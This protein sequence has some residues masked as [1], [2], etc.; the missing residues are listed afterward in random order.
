MSST[1]QNCTCGCCNSELT[2]AC[3]YPPNEE[4]LSCQAWKCSAGFYPS[5]GSTAICP[6]GDQFNTFDVNTL[7]DIWTGQNC[8]DFYRGLIFS[9]GDSLAPTCEGLSE[10]Q[11]YMNNFLK[12][13]TSLGYDFTSDTTSSRWN[14]FQDQLISFCANN[15]L[16]PGACDLFLGNGPGIQGY[17]TKF[18]RSEIGGDIDLNDMCGCYAPSSGLSL[19]SSS[20]DS[21][22]H[23]LTTVQRPDPTLPGKTQVCSDT[24]CVLDDVNINLVNTTGNELIFRQICPACTVSHPCTCIISGVNVNE[25][26][27]K[28]GIGPIYQ[29]VCGPTNAQCYNSASG[30]PE[31]TTCPPPTEFINNQARVI[32]PIVFVIVLVVILVIIVVVFS[33]TRHTKTEYEVPK[34]LTSKQR[35]EVG[36]M[37]YTSDD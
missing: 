11:S 14:P 21:I 35:A 23:L 22:C 37:I 12:A 18:T 7:E 6:D 34:D 32:F 8:T 29:Q 30:S 26:M 9:S 28:S 17:C 1:Q 36:A 15:D 5:G 20:C 31:I 24:V 4:F 13:Y 3:V 33:M 2:P 19:P 16:N 10:A 27:E 25:T